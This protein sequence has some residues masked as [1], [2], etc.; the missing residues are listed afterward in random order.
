MM[1]SYSRLLELGD[2]IMENWN[3]VDF[4][5]KIYFFAVMTVLEQNQE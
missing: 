4:N 2:Q 1:N 5:E 3:F